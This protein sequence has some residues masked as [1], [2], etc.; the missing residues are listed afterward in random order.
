M[1]RQAEQVRYSPLN[2]PSC[3]LVNFV[4]QFGLNMTRTSIRSRKKWITVRKAVQIAAL[5]LFIALVVIAR[6]GGLPELINVPLRLDPLLMLAHALATRVLL[7]GSLLA[8]IVVALTLVFGRAWCGWLCP[9]GTVLDLFTFKRWRKK[10]AGVSDRWRAV[11]YV[12]LLTIIVA[13][14]FGNLTLLIFD[15]IT[16]MVRTVSI[17]VWP[18]LDQT[19]TSLEHTLY[20]VPFLQEAIGT[21]DSAVRPTIFPIDPDVLS[22]HRVVRVDLRRHRRAQRYRAA[23]LVPLSLPAG[24]LPRRD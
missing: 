24:R 19:V 17:G 6:G 8:L 12:L 10:S 14:L 3:V 18:A 21:F 5:L 22:R 2:S 16:I 7:V 20:Q 9:L 15:P 4:D 23:L 13:A 1:A 11:K